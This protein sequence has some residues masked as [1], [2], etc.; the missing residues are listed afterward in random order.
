MVYLRE[1]DTAEF[2]TRSAEL[3]QLAEDE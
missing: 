2:F 1:M 3:K